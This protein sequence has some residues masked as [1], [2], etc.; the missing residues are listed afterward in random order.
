MD[1]LLLKEKGKEKDF[2]K[3]LSDQ[4][5]YNISFDFNNSIFYEP[6]AAIDE[7][8][9]FKIDDF[10]EKE[11]CLEILK[12]KG[13]DSTDFDMADKNIR[14]DYANYLLSY[15]NK[16]YFIFQR[17]YSRDIVRKKRVTFIKDDFKIDESTGF[18]I[19]EVPD[20][21]YLKDQDCLYFKKLET[22]SPIFKGIDILFQEATEEETEEFLDSDFIDLNEDYDVKKVNKSNRKRIALA[23][24]TL[25]ELS[26]EKR[27]QIFTYTYEYYP[28]LDFDGKAFKINNDKDLKELLYGIEE[29]LFTTPIS[30][31][32][33]CASRIQKI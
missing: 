29:R 26:P 32:K 5:V 4:G 17:I 30:G 33:R 24:K 11:Y 18:T 28:N 16:N 10:S 6:D 8:Q 12:Q 9:W 31:E 3:L 20:A 15:Q 1:C 23:I 2:L 13:F 7:E 21:I 27:T 19:N 25:R 22:I 14:L